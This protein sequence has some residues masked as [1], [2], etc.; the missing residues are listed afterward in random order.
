[1]PLV[2]DHDIRRREVAEIAYGLI[3]QG[4]T[5]AATVRNVAAVAGYSTNIVSHYFAGKKDLLQATFD[6]SLVSSWERVSRAIETGDI[7][8]VLEALL[9]IDE[10]QCNN[11]R[12]WFAFWG[13]AVSDHEFAD[14]QMQQARNIRQILKDFYIE[15]GLCS[16]NLSEDDVDNL[17][18]STVSVIVGL[19][20]QAS[21][22]PDDWP[23]SKQRHVINDHINFLKAQVT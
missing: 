9:P 3:A 10:I 15:S 8:Q 23:P 1:M 6:L 21:F 12:I 20:T 11:W 13:A 14:Q 19:A 16:T 2:V 7:H 5:D 22:D 17:A 18:R 4:S